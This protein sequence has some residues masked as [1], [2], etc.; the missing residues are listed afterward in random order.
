MK[1]SV[2]FAGMDISHKARQ[3]AQSVTKRVGSINLVLATMA[4]VRTVPPVP[5]DTGQ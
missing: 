4:V 3:G 1:Q 2:S 5:K